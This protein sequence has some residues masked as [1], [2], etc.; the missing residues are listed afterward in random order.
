[1]HKWLTQTEKGYILRIQVV[2]NSSKTQ[3][4]GEHGERLKVKIS[5]PPVDGKA[6]EELIEFV[7]KKLNLKS[8]QIELLRGQTSKAKDLL[9]Q[10]A[11]KD[12]FDLLIKP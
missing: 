8:S 11:S 12:I 9:V 3:V 6:N 10:S 2:P 4:V 1:M 5:A 7:Q